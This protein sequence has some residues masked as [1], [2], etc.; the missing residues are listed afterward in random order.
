LLQMLSIADAAATGPAAWSDWKGALFA[1][2]TARSRAALHGAELPATPPL[3]DE[4][5]ELAE[6]G[7]LAVIMRDR[8]VV[9]A[10]PD[11]VGVLYRT[12]GVLALHLLDI[13]Q[14][15]IRTYEGMAVN[16]FVVEPRFGRTPDATL[17]RA[18]LA[19]ALNGEMPLADRLREKERAYS[20]RGRK[21]PPTIKW[22][23][24]EATDATVLEIRTEDS[25]GLLTRITAALE[26]AGTNVS[27]ARISSLGFSVVAA[28][29]LTDRRG[30]RI[31]PAA[32]AD[33][34]VEL[35]RI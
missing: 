2:L 10:A 11:G 19:R 14:A 28:F 32:R 29:Y 34:E 30:R 31:S 33:I 23:D 9:V 3:D 16:A 4:R 35:R 25:I 5:R 13:R 12:A 24:E 6:A 20:E 18:D 8:D 1:E 21:R 26:R 7:K 22:F 17:V 27:G 15:S